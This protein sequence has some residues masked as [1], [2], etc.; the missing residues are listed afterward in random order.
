MLAFTICIVVLLIFGA[1]ASYA[2]V[3]PGAQ[4]LGKALVKGS[5]EIPTI[6]LTFDDGPGQATPLILDILKASGVRATFFLCGQNVERYPEI[7]R[8]IAAEGHEIGNHTYSHPHLFWKSPGRIAWEITHAQDVIERVTGCRPVLFRPPFGG[9][10]FGLSTILASHGLG[11]VTWS[12]SGVDW[13]WPASR[14]ARRV[15]EKT[16]A[17]SIIL[18][19]D[20]VP[21]NEP[22]DRT[23]TAEA[24][25]EI[26]RGLSQRYRFVTASQM[27]RSD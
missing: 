1:L 9:R 11:L 5:G 25:P 27:T 3:A 21:Q 7:A 4:I 18:L 10:W 6:A 17:G 12:V 16:T 8:R 19:H 14:I 20:G 22:G 13:K 23:P 24:L 15:A 26:V 2:L